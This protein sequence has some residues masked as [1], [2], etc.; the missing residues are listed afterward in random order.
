MAIRP[1]IP[2]PLDEVAVRMRTA[3]EMLVRHSDATR[4]HRELAL[5]AAEILIVVAREMLEEEG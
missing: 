1:P 3:G 5:D 4:D 2:G